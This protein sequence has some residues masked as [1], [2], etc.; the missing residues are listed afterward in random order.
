MNQV[1][2]NHLKKQAK[3]Q[4]QQMMTIRHANA[5]KISLINVLSLRFFSVVNPTRACEHSK[6]V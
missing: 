4:Q 2:I 5:N 6:V 3:Q 1:L